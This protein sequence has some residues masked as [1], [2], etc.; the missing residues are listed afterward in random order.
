MIG[1]VRLRIVQKEIWR[2]LKV[3]FETIERE[4]VYVTA[5]RQERA[6]PVA[7]SKSRRGSLRNRVPGTEA[8]TSITWR[9]GDACQ[10][11]FDRLVPLCLKANLSE[12]VLLYLAHRVSRQAVNEEYPLG[13][14]V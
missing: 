4:G 6:S 3:A 2:R 7:L 12:R 5:S 9:G 8:S 13:C 14:L 10:R 11:C 1:P